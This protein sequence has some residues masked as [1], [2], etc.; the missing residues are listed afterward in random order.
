MVFNVPVGVT[1]NHMS[2]INYNLLKVKAW[3]VVCDCYQVLT[4]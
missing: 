1:D 3:N 4:I 2:T